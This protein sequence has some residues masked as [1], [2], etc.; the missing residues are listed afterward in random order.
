MA[1]SEELSVDAFL[2]RI[3]CLTRKAPTR[4]FLAELQQRHLHAVP[5]ENL[6][7]LAG[8]ALSLQ[9][10][11]LYEKIVLARRGGYCFEL[12][13]L[14]AWLLRK[15][16]YE[17]VHYVARF[18]RDEPNLPPKRRHHVLGVRVGDDWYLTDVGVGGIVPQHPVRLVANEEN[19]QGNECYRL[20]R[21]ARFGWVLME[22][23]RGIWNR[24]YS[25]TE[26]PQEEG[27]FTFADF[28]CQTAPAS[29]FRREA[30]LAIRTEYG[31]NS[32]AG[33][34]FRLFRPQGVESFVP[35]GPKAY[36]EALEEH[37][38]LHLP[39]DFPWDPV[40]L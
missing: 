12:N 35:E 31:R 3:G 6:D 19:P 28:W 38:G 24:L 29:I 5:Y 22:L 8:K 21:D 20:E 7:I 25:F 39:E 11:A 18:W 15:L 27:D 26:E 4:E 33:R 17:V 37:F 2:T 32:V 10:P 16:G 30:M 1:T 40:R 36:R 9:I 13:A 14:F 23:K 34:E